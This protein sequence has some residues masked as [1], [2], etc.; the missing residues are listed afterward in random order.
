[1]IPGVSGVRGGDQI[2]EVGLLCERDS[3]LEAGDLDWGARATPSSEPSH[4]LV[5]FVPGFFV[6]E[7]S[8]AQDGS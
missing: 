5:D 1:M 6:D 2:T 7:G 8:E 3:A 4:G